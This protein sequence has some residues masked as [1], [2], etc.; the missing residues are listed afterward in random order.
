MVDSNI[1]RTKILPSE[2]AFAYKMKLEAEKHQGKR[3]DLTS[4][5]LATKSKRATDVIEES[6]GESRDTIYRYIR[7]TE[8]MPEILQMVDDEEIAF[9]PAVEMS[10]L[11]NG[12]QYILLDN[13]QMYDATPS[14]AQAIHMKKLS[15]EGKLTADKIDEIMGEEKP[16]QIPKVKFNE[17]RLRSVLPSHVNTQEQIEDFV[18][19]CIQEHN[20]REK[21]KMLSR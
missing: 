15:Q 12:E 21:S 13:M 2:K 8:L 11:T 16:N 7:L 10:Y 1:Q 6:T 19:T 9:T 17:D 3:T 18:I 14:L 4:S 5:Q 20:Q